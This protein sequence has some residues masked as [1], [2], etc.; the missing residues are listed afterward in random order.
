M[1]A[2]LQ[3][4][5]FNAPKF[6]IPAL[7]D[8]GQHWSLLCQRND[9]ICAVASIDLKALV[10]N[11]NWKLGSLFRTSV[12]NG[13]SLKIL[14]Y[15]EWSWCKLHWIHTYIQ[16]LWGS[17]ILAYSPFCQCWCF[18]FCRFLTIW[19][20]GKYPPGSLRNESD[21]WCGGT[22]CALLRSCVTSIPS[23]N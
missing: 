22:I 8:V 16:N 1:L 21:K 10:P 18:C 4:K 14:R 11:F 6:S 13:L 5:F 7:S 15:N 3:T 17:I 19:R 2:Y 23:A 12:N 20:L 9:N